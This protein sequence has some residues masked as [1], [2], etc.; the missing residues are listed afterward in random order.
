MK[1]NLRKTIYV[2]G[3]GNEVLVRKIGQR[4]TSASIKPEGVYFNEGNG[5][6]SGISVAA[7]RLAPWKGYVDNPLKFFLHAD[8]FVHSAHVESLGNVL[9]E[10]MMCGCTPVSIDCPNRTTRSPAGW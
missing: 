3:G 6:F 8:V 5:H 4:L 10:A 2:T 7:G 9:V 1:I